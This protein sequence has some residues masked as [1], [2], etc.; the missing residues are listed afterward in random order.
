MGGSNTGCK[1][2]IND[3]PKI[4]DAPDLNMSLFQDTLMNKALV[5]GYLDV[6]QIQF[7]KLLTYTAHL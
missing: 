6:F 7:G 4:A 2:K 1:L 5:L 3:N